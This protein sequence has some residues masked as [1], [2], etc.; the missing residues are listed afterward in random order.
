[1]R[2]TREVIGYHIA[3][4]DGEIG[5][6]DDFVIN[7]GSWTVRHIVV[8]TSNCREPPFDYCPM[9]VSPKP[10]YNSMSTK[11]LLAFACTMGGQPDTILTL[12]D[13]HRR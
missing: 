10:C 8:D 13:L 6:V 1:L 5:H 11:Y 12:Y 3:A 2:S 7:D 4:S 9:A